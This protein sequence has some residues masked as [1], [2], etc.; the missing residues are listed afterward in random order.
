M[1][2]QIE[3]QLYRD[4][5]KANLDNNIFKYSKI[6]AIHKVDY[7]CVQLKNMIHHI[8]ALY[9]ITSTKDSTIILYEDNANVLHNSKMLY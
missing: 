1:F 9:G 3:K 7:E 8:Q 4:I 2:L 6:I 5:C